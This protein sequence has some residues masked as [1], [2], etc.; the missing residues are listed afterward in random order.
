MHLQGHSLDLPGLVRGYQAVPLVSH[1]ACLGLAH[2]LDPLP[3]EYSIILPVPDLVRLN[4]VLETSVLDQASTEAKA[5]GIFGSERSPNV[6]CGHLLVIVTAA[7]GLWRVLSFLCYCLALDEFLSACLHLVEGQVPIHASWREEGIHEIL[8]RCRLIDHKHCLAA[9]RS[10]WA[11]MFNSDN[12]IFSHPCLRRSRRRYQIKNCDA[13]LR[14]CGKLVFGRGRP[15][16]VVAP[17][18][19]RELIRLLQRFHFFLRLFL[20]KVL[21]LGIS[22]DAQ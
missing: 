6:P 7:A 9:L 1:S 10:V 5:L 16:L 3:A 2:H 17:E 20:A 4:R 22:R 15:R 21:D 8:G 12:F 18:R 11:I 19:K 13:I 14:L